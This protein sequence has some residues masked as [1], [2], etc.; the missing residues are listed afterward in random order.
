[1]LRVVLLVVDMTSSV[2]YVH[3]ED[4]LDKPGFNVNLCKECDVLKN[5]LLCPFYNLLM[6]HP[7]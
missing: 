7:V 3:N 4:E 1:M 6:Q 5:E 2:A